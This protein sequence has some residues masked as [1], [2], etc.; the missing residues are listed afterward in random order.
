[1][2]KYRPIKELLEKL[3][4]EDPCP[5]KGKHNKKAIK[6]RKYAISKLN[7]E[8]YKIGTAKDYDGDGY[9]KVPVYEYEGVKYSRA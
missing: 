5:E 1:M 6:E 2:N 9:F 4:Y 3:G 8:Q 7:L